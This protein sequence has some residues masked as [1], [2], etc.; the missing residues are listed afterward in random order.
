MADISL[1][2]IIDIL[3]QTVFDGNTDVASLAVMLAVFLVFV[4][5]LANIHAPP[6][7]S[8]VPMIPLAILFRAMNVLSTDLAM[9]IIVLS[10]VFVAMAARGIATGGR[11]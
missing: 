1:N 11:R 5:I 2:S 7:Y 4:V 9:L 6:V 3:A 10:A 8:L